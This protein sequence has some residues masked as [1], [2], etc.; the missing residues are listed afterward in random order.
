MEN[1]VA[2]TGPVAAGPGTP[3]PSP[4]AGRMRASLRIGRITGIEIRVHATFA[5]LIALILLTAAAPD[6]PSIPSQL[7]W[8]V[9]IFASVTVHEL[10][11]SLVARRFGIEVAEIDL[12]PIGGVSRF[13]SL[14][15][16]PRQ[17]L[18]VAIAGPL[19]SVAVGLGCAIVALA[20]GVS[21]WPPS[22]VAGSLLARAAWA[23]LLLAGFN[24]LPAF[25]LDGGRVL[26]AYLAERRDGDAA[27]MLAARVGGLLAGV[28]MVAGVMTNVWLLAIGVFVWFGSWAEGSAAVVHS[29]IG[30]LRVRDVMVPSVPADLAGE[31]GQPVDA[32]SLV[33]DAELLT[34]G[35]PARPVVREGEVV[36]YVTRA[37]LRAIVERLVTEWYQRQPARTAR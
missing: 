6:A 15:R 26:R 20:A 5:L 19:I 16:E 34:S 8:I 7:V 1:H 30:A 25:P 23:N 2:P 9:V 14:P 32:D 36:G 31:L 3:G 13:R 27:T 22:L 29:A 24:L 33:A 18:D 21:A 10:A 28:M 17:Q 4:P 37:E 12:L 11:H 35:P